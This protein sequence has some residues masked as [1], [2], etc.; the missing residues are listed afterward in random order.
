MKL[1][2][3]TYLFVSALIFASCKQQSVNGKIKGKVDHFE[4]Q[5]IY[6]Q[7]IGEN[8]DENI[9]SSKVNRDGSFE[10]SNPSKETDYFILRADS[11]NLIFLVLS[12][13]ENVSVD[14]D[15]KN[16]EITY[17]VKGSKDSE[18]LKALRSYDRNLSDSLNKI[19]SETR[20]N[21]PENSDS[22]GL[23]LQGHYTSTMEIYSKGFIKE[24]LKSL[25]S[26]SAT[27]YLN[28][29]A[30]LNLLKELEK[31]LLEVYPKNKYVQDYKQLI[32]GYLKLPVGSLAPEISLNTAKGVNIKLSS[33]RGKIVLIDFWASWCAPCRREN[34]TIAEAYKKFKGKDFEI[35][36]V[37]L[38]NNIEAWTEAVNHDKITW[39]QVSD[40]K[41][42]DSEV[43]KT[44]QIEAIPT[45]VLI[46][47]E[48]RIISK[49][50]R[51]EDLQSK[52]KE[53]LSKSS[54]N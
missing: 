30:E 11:A 28:Q 3:L 35:Y 22:I 18:L 33:L 44:Y 13:G 29:Q 40:L 54:S 41:R 5:Y 47:K 52:I 6:L 48:G 24:N 23:L 25:V 36:G 14:G 2:I 32:E 9:D 34:P 38:D 19:Y 8:G 20:S 17:T 16:L 50:I 4:H 10:M 1:K 15:A 43:A 51:G 31:N 53:A 7:K 26:L 12:P 45:N 46:D 49:G 42:W 39:I 27:K 37:S 21:H